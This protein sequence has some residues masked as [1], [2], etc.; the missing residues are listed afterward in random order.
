[1]TITRFCIR[2]GDSY[3]QSPYHLWGFVLDPRQLSVCLS[4]FV[5]VMREG[6]GYLPSLMMTTVSNRSYQGRVVEG[7]LPEVEVGAAAVRN[8]EFAELPTTKRS[9]H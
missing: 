9:I 4:A 6:E 7:R 5:R 3:Q 2:I 8:E 1:L